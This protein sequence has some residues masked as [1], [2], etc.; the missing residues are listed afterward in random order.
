M[1]PHLKTRAELVGDEYVINGSKAFIS[2]AGS[3]DVL[4]RH[5]AHGRG[6]GA[7]GISAF[8]VPADTPGISYG[9]NEDK[10]GWNSQPTRTISFD[11]VRIPA[12]HLHRPGGRGLQVSP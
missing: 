3:T 2:G 10:M 12:N 7:K 8:P 6:S 11:G 9:K 1:P 5:G 4:M